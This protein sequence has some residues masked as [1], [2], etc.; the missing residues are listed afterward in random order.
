MF[1]P[2]KADFPLPRFPLLTV[3]IC[4]VCLGVHVKQQM[5]WQEYGNAVARFCAADRSNLERMIF[6]RAADVM[7][8]RGCADVMFQIA[9][10]P[11]L[12]PDEV[13]AEIAREVRPLTGLS[14][15][16]SREY[17]QQ[18]L[19]EETRRYLMRVP[20]D[21]DIG[22]AYY[23]GSWNPITMITSGFAHGDW[24][25]LGFNLVFFF[26][27]AATVEILVGPLWFVA[28][29]LADSWFIG[30]TGSLFAS[31][32]AQHYWTVGLSGI[33]MGVMGMFAFLLPHGKIRCYYFFIVIFGSIAIPGW[34]LVAWY[35]GKDVITLLA[36]EDYGMVNVMAHVM[37][38]LGGYLFGF[39][40]LDDVRRKAIALQADLDWREKEQRLR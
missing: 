29:I 11:E 35:L 27:F 17:V 31:L 32:G 19:K 40:F 22:I 21:P 15:S 5:D 4:L 33:V 13:I 37:G 6:D 30:V 28:F 10:D 36:Q 23:T 18:K 7:R 34:I 1:L 9:N 25:H 3:L 2:V 16:A 12:E 24:L 26:A 14:V 20:E 39:L 38:G 8:N